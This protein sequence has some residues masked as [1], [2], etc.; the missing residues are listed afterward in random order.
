MDSAERKYIAGS[1]LDLYTV[2]RTTEVLG[3]LAIGNDSALKKPNGHNSAEELGDLNIT[4]GE[5]A[6][7][8]SKVCVQ[9]PE[10]LKLYT[11]FANNDNPQEAVEIV[12]KETGCGESEACA[13]KSK[14]FNEFAKKNDISTFIIKKELESSF[15]PEG[16]LDNEWTSNIELDQTLRLWAHEFPNFYNHQINMMDFYNYGGSLAKIKIIDILNGKA[17]QQVSRY[18]NIVHRPCKKIGCV[19]NTDTSKGTGQHWV[20]L[21]V[22]CTALFNSHSSAKCTIE[23]FDSAGKPPP[24]AYPHDPVPPLTKLMESMKHDLLAYQKA[25]A[26]NK[27]CPIEIVC[28]FGIQ[29]QFSRSECG[30]YSLY[31]IRRRLENTPYKYF[32]NP[33]SIVKDYDMLEFR[34]LVFRSP[35]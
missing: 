27:T 11:E 15:K 5:C 14:K 3:G 2:Q 23:Y 21:F 25:Y 32:Y 10:I 33:D 22:D 35:K 6:L 16:P 12:K 1:I 26:P 8:D 34:K 19:L 24:K 29:H 30:L 18:D 28:N 31:Y 17:G 7:D 13:L 9:N 20:A 4:K